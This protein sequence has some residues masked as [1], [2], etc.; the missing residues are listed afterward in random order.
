MPPNDTRRADADHARLVILSMLRTETM[1]G[2]A[3]SK[4]IARR[5]DNHFRMTPGVLYP[6][7]REMETQGLISSSVE[8]VRSERRED[9]HASERKPSGEDAREDAG[10]DAERGGRKR[11]W[12]K[13]TAKGRRR[14]EASLEAHHA[15]RRIIDAFIGPAGGTAGAGEAGRV[16]NTREASR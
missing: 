2:Y 10:E 1:Y 6:L 16:A 4:E 3:I 13:L 12:Y 7:L 5:S 11:K 9:S 14:L 8:E 15:W